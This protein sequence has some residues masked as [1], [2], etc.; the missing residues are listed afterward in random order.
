[1]ICLV[2][3]VNG[4]TAGVTPSEDLLAVENIL[5]KLYKSFGDKRIECPNLEIASSEEFV[6]KYSPGSHKIVIEQ[7]AIDLCKDFGDKDD[8]ALAFILGHE[9]AHA[10]QGHL[11]HSEETSFLAYNKAY[12]T[13]TK[14]KVDV[15]LKEG[16]ADVFGSFGAYLA[17]YEIHKVFPDLINTIYSTYGLTDK[18]LPQYPSKS[19]RNKSAKKMMT[20][21]DSLVHLYDL[22]NYLSL[23]GNYVEAS[24]CY[25]EVG[26]SYKGIELTNNKGINNLLE[27]LNMSKL[28]SEPYFY[29]LELDLNSRLHKAK[30]TSATK[31]LN[32]QE[33]MLF[34]FLLIDAI[35]AFTECIDMDPNYLPSYVNM[36]C[37]L[38]IENEA[39]KALDFINEYN[40][41]SKIYN[42][43]TAD[44]RASYEIAKAICLMKTGK[45]EE[46]E[47]LLK[48]LRSTSNE[49]IS[50]LADINLNGGA[51][52]SG[53]S[54]AGPQ[55]NVS[56]LIG[57]YKNFKP[58]KTQNS[59][60][61]SDNN[62]ELS[63]WSKSSKD[64]YNI[65]SGAKEIMVVVSESSLGQE[66]L[67]SPIFLNKD[68]RV[69]KDHN[70][71][72]IKFEDDPKEVMILNK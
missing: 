30:R 50:L 28:N 5:D 2:L 29:P 67:S 27:A 9:L 6:A 70:I 51:I 46:G 23:S 4:L 63:Y 48:A 43:A 59:V 57:K 58:S 69:L 65:Q 61:D 11:D 32:P 31:D 35:Q 64:F 68:L 8:D 62:I 15:K 56:K 44:T 45:T 1:M 3:T 72:L 39:E 19:V 47:K 55:Q 40:V 37:A 34:N 66:I 41:E 24:A 10:F 20:K 22:A 38:G 33:Q 26:Q 53:D 7:K 12:S 18:I 17:G 54:E 16:E 49:N 71:T 13:S 21:L 52:N 14:S 36:I 60:L 42:N 25:N